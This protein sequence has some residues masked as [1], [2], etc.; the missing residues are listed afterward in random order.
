[1][2]TSHARSLGVAEDV[3]LSIRVQHTELY[4]TKGTPTER[5][6]TW[7]FIHQSHQSTLTTD[8]QNQGAREF[9]TQPGELALQPW[10]QRWASRRA[11]AHLLH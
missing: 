8:H 5:D 3:I 4:P 10:L 11:L 6:I 1:M 9:R 7:Q 2:F